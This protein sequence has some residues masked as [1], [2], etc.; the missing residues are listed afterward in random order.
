MSFGTASLTAVIYAKDV[1]RLA[2]FY[3]EALSLL[4]ADEGSDFIVWAADSL[5]LSIVQ[6][7]E[8]IAASIK[9]TEPPKIRE[10]TP[11]KLAFQVSNI[12]RVRPTIQR[13]GG[14]LKEQGATWSSRG[15]KHLDGWDPEGN[16]IQWKQ[17][18]A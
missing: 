11:I 16:V 6:V 12:E 7:P 3:E 2:S 10:D 9:I 17:A 18:E 15:A 5:D 1:Q 8:A 4:R 13:M 14:G